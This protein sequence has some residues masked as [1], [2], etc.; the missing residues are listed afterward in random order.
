MS[1]RVFFKKQMNED[2]LTDLFGKLS[3]KPKV[4]KTEDTGKIFEMAIC[5]VYNIPYE[6]VYKYS[7]EAATALKQRLLKF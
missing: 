2:E 5:L 7:L 6:G 3:V 4:V 1:L